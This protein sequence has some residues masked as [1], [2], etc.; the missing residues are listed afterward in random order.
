[1]PWRVA[2]SVCGLA[3]QVFAGW[4]CLRIGLV[5]K[6]PCNLNLGML[7]D[8]VAPDLPSLTSFDMA[9]SA[10]QLAGQRVNPLGKGW[11]R[12]KISTTVTQRTT[13]VL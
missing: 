4:R 8:A 5:G 2:A 6:T 10:P 9:A 3:L 7:T 1:M 11:M 12:G 13:F